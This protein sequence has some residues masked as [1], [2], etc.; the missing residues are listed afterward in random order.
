MDSWDLRNF[1]NDLSIFIDLIK[2]NDV[3]G[4]FSDLDTLLSEIDD[5]Q[6]IEYDL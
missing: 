1:R 4:D 5:K 3:T 2:T 6:L